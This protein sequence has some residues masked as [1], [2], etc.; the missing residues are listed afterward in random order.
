MNLH[1]ARQILKKNGYRL[2]SEASWDYE[3]TKDYKDSQD[4]AEEYEPMVGDEFDKIVLKIKENLDEEFPGTE[5]AANEV[6]FEDISTFGRNP[7]LSCTAEFALPA[8][9]VEYLSK[10][11][12]T[13]EYE[14]EYER[15][16][17]IAKAGIEEID[18]NWYYEADFTDDSEMLKISVTCSVIYDDNAE[19]L[20]FVWKNF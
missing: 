4:Y 8:E 11:A 19:E 18:D 7:V 13:P 6:E 9:E 12:D 2:I 16:W 3:E 5:I 10:I 20:K 1:E 15:I 17:E 14:K